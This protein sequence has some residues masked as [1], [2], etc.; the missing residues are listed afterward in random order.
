MS[1]TVAVSGEYFRST[2]GEVIHLAP[3][4][5]MGNAMRWS[6]ADGKSLHDVVAEVSAADWIRLC[7]RCW[8][9]DALATSDEQRR[10]TAARRRA[11]T[12]VQIFVGADNAGKDWRDF[13]PVDAEILANDRIRV[14]GI[15]VGPGE[16]GRWFLD[17]RGQVTWYR[18]TVDAPRE[19]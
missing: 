5:S 8:P 9:T 15:E 13:V 2:S 14:D 7:R 11:L 19:G 17:D 18:S 4:P 16:G 3:C 1:E 12:Y 6:Y 10:I